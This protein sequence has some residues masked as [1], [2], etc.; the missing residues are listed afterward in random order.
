MTA[1]HAARDTPKL[2]VVSPLDSTD[3]SEQ[4][5]PNSKSP[6]W[7]MLLTLLA[8]IVWFGF[9]TLELW[10]ERQNYRSAVERQAV[11]IER[12]Q[13]MQSAFDTLTDDTARLAAAG[14]PN[15]RLLLDALKKR[16][17]NVKSEQQ[18]TATGR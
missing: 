15:A 1:V 2:E 10:T 8:L 12:L 6:F 9:Q 16:G 18:A 7:P 14:N 17:V 4:A 13:P 3:P 5:G 11:R